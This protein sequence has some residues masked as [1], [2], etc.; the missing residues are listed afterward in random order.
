MKHYAILI[1]H[2]H[3]SLFVTAKYVTREFIYRNHFLKIR[4]MLLLFFRISG[5]TKISVIESLVWC[6]PYYIQ[7]PV[8]FFGSGYKLQHLVSII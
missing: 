5:E 7:V 1:A 6:D 3:N 4:S 8:L 2:K